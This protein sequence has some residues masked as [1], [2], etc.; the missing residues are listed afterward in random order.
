MKS[1]IETKI[2]PRIKGDGGWVE[3]SSFEKGE[4]TLIFRGECSKCVVLDRCC[5]WIEEEIRKD[6]KQDIHIKAKRI[7]PFFW[8]VD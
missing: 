5:A 1:Y 4:L 6:L 7:K 8:D 3:F 2:A